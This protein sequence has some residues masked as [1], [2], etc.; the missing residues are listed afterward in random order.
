MLGEKVYWL[1]MIEEKKL[2]IVGEDVNEL[3]NLL[4]KVYEGIVQMFRC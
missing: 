2:E 4:L 1:S 3:F